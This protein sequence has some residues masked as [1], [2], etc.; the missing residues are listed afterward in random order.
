[1]LFIHCA[2]ENCVKPLVWMIGI[3]LIGFLLNPAVGKEETELDTTDVPEEYRDIGDSTADLPAML[4]QR[5]IRALVTYNQ[6]HYFNINGQEHGFEYELLKEYEKYL[7]KNISSKEIQ[8]QIMFIPVSFEQLI[9]A[10]LAGQGDIAAAGLTITEDRQRQVSFSTPYIPEVAE[11][12]VAH[13]DAKALDSLDDLA[14]ESVYVLRASSYAQHLATLHED[15]QSEAKQPIKIIEADPYLQEGDIL[16]MV[17]AGILDYTVVDNHIAEIWASVLPEITLYPQLEI[18]SGGAIAWAV[19]PDNPKLLKNINT[20]LEK[21][22][23]GSLLGNVLFERY[24]ENT[25][26]IK[27]PISEKERRKSNTVIDLFKKYGAQYGFDWLILMAQ[28]YQE[29]GLDHDTVSSAGAIGI[30]QLLP[31]TAADPNVGIKNI[32]D[33]EKNIHAGVKYLHFLRERYFSDP[34]IAP[35]AQVHFAHAAYNAGPAR[36]REMRKLA[37]KMGLDPNRWYFN[38]ERA[39][40]RIVGQETVRYVANIQKYYVAYTLALEKNLKRKA[41]RQE[42]KERSGDKE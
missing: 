16:E 40:L 9:P 31:R 3:F 28:A 23:K 10:L 33:L 18:H 6:V 29:S 15:L 19:R 41:A 5:R 2:A 30:M 11:I 7:N 42:L 17:N 4:K 8:L 14:G 32:R 38:T 37:A 20:F 22:K 34:A 35:D 12:I 26:W 27:N 25:Q 1:V 36:V 39:A 13:K 24:F 21:H